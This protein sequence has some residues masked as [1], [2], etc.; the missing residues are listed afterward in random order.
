MADQPVAK[1]VGETEILI[2]STSRT[3]VVPLH[4]SGIKFEVM[5]WMDYLLLHLHQA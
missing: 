2:I 1:T 5:E 3:V 4:V